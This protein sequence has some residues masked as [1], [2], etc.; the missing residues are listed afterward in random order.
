[1]RISCYGLLFGVLITVARGF[2]CPLSGTLTD[3]P[4]LAVHSRVPRS[5]DEVVGTYERVTVVSAFAASSFAPRLNQRRSQSRVAA[6]MS[7]AG[8]FP[9]S[10]V[11]LWL[12]RSG[13]VART[14]ALAV[15]HTKWNRNSYLA[16]QILLTA[17]M[18][19][20]GGSISWLASIGIRSSR[21]EARAAGECDADHSGPPAT[22]SRVAIANAPRASRPRPAP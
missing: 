8:S 2:A 7:Q 19:I 11:T 1:M 9:A 18:L 13:S 22:P 15:R 5:R 4:C 14:H 6:P 3:R 21:R 16:V 10:R 17:S 20:V 12:T